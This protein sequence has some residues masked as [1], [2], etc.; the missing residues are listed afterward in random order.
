VRTYKSGSACTISV[1]PELARAIFLA[2]ILLDA[3]CD[4]RP[5]I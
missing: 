5:A 1:P 3:A 2:P 4:A